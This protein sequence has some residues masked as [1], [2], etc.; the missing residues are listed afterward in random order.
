[1]EQRINY[2]KT[3]REVV[4][5]MMGLEEYKKTTEIDSALIESMAVRTAWICIQRM[6]GQ[7]VKRNKEF[8]V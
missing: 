8:T 6:P 2:M 7:W 1:M 5:L 4:K 3:N